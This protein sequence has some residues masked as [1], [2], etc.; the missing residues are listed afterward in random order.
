MSSDTPLFFVAA[1]LIVVLSLHVSHVSGQGEHVT[2]DEPDGDDEL[3]QRQYIDRLDGHLAHYVTMSKVTLG[4]M[5]KAM[6]ALDDIKAGRRNFMNIANE[7]S[8]SNAKA[9]RQSAALQ[10]G[11]LGLITYDLIEE[12]LA[13][14]AF[15]IRQPL[16][17]SANDLIGPICSKSGCSLIAVFSRYRKSFFSQ[18]WFEAEQ[19]CLDNDMQLSDLV[20]RL[21]TDEMVMVASVVWP[22]E[23]VTFRKIKI[24]QL[25][26][27]LR[28]LNQVD[29]S[30]VF[31]PE[32]LGGKRD[33]TEHNKMMKHRE[34]IFRYAGQEVMAA[35]P[36]I[37]AMSLPQMKASGFIQPEAFQK[38][39]AEAQDEARAEEIAIADVAASY[40][41]VDK[42]KMRPKKHQPVQHKDGGADSPLTAPCNDE[43]SS[44]PGSPDV[45]S[46]GQDSLAP[47]HDAVLDN[48]ASPPTSSPQHEEL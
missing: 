37:Y 44:C 24:R 46:Q 40:E 19:F 14:V 33:M 43:G 6:A 21:N 30:T 47:Q 31:K 27:D 5:P 23:H 3:S 2:L 4:D 8:V 9:G 1:S 26:G 16:A 13:E 17:K 36:E 29:P 18:A 35:H 10:N 39:D 12:E 45:I 11:D 25:K 32:H 48:G 38:A 7:E 15:D 22:D 28:K 34:A 20:S 41:M 42:Y